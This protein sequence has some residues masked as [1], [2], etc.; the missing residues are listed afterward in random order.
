MVAGH[1]SLSD[2]YLRVLA[3][4]LV[5]VGES[6][7]SGEIGVAEEH[8]ATQIVIEQMNRL[9]SLFVVSEKRSPYRVLVACLEGER[10]FV[11][12]RMVA[13]LC[14]L[15]GWSVDFLGPDTPTTALVEMAKK[16]HSH[17]VAVSATMAQCKALVPPLIEKLEK[18]TPAPNVVLG[19]QLFAADPSP[20]VLR[21]GCVT[22][23]DAAEGVELIGR[24]LRADRPK[25][26]LKEYLLALGRRVRDLRTRKAWTQEQLAEATRVTR[27]CIVAVEGGRQNV[28]MDILVRLANALSVAPEVLLS[29]EEDLVNVPRREA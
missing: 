29:G 23:R 6:W 4:A 8:L 5:S 26:V 16:R 25:A 10:H 24:F 22:A 3:P 21:R 18:L 19:G 20:D 15:R 9:R 27:V 12:A 13:D 1:R 11:G 14:L 7:C 2:I 17:L 28:S